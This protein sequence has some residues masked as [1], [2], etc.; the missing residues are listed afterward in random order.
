MTE[1]VSETSDPSDQDAKPEMSFPPASTDMIQVVD[2]DDN[3]NPTLNT[4]LTDNRLTTHGF[5][6]HVASILGAQSSGKSTLLNM[7]FGTR[8][9]T[10]DEASGRYQVTQG[11]W[12]GLDPAARII[13]LDLEGTDSRERGEGAVNFERKIALFALA[14]SEVL[15]VNVWAQDVGRYNA[16]N[17]DLL[18][19]VMEL[20][21]QLFFGTSDSSPKASVNQSSPSDDNTPISQ[22]RMHKTR[23]LFV[24]RDHVS[25]PFEA[26]CATLRTDVENIWSTISKP[27][28]AADIP[29]TH[30]FDLDFFALPH[31]ILMAPAFEEQGSELRRRFKDGEIF[32]EEYHSGIA[33]DGF[34]EYANA[35][36]E[37][38]RANRELDIPT[39]KEML[40]HVRCE[41]IAK[42]ALEGFETEIADVT[43]ALQGEDAHVVPDLIATLV[44]A[45]NTALEQYRDAAYRYSKPV[46]DDKGADLGSRI[47]GVAKDLVDVQMSI[48]S[49]AAV[50]SVQKSLEARGEDADE[51]WSG[52]NETRDSL[53]AK[54]LEGFG[55]TCGA[56]GL[57]EVDEEHAL[58][59]MRVMVEVERRRVE[60]RM[61][62]DVS[63][64]DA[65]IRS[66][67]AVHCASVFT[68]GM[69]GPMQAVVDAASD[70]VWERV[71]EVTDASWEAT[72]REARVV[73]GSDG[74]GLSETEQ[75]D[76]IEDVLKPTCHE[77]AVRS[78]RETIGSPNHLLMRMTKRFDDAFRFDER[79]VP[80]HFGPGEDIE[81]LFVA[82]RDRAEALVDVLA[83]VR[84]QGTIMELRDAVAKKV[85]KRALA[86]GEDATG[87]LSDEMCAEL[88][89][90]LKRQ[91][92][93]VFIEVKRAQE[94]ARVTA[95]V[96]MWLM[97]LI[98][99]L[100]WNEF[101]TVVKSPILLFM[102]VMVMPVM[103]VAYIVD[104]PTL[105]GPAI[106]ATVAPYADQ[107]KGIVEM[108]TEGG[109]DG[110][111]GAGAGGGAVAGGGGVGSEASSATVV[112]ETRSSNTTAVAAGSDVKKAE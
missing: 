53:V 96:P 104:A 64:V 58:A 72:A 6:Y 83:H 60:N 61:Q 77:T 105:L 29:L 80:R 36:W 59:P 68:K 73:Y 27:E 9:N 89:E 102:S 109:A 11:V 106:W 22:Q 47:L 8:F 44:T 32:E 48:A 40:A 1:P 100:G 86:D 91:A 69:K 99:I 107:A 18:K 35:V 66:R 10:M 82:A 28:S 90:K 19:T 110:T 92:G 57:D 95:K 93:A 112:S 54:V 46:A 12:L 34:S 41:Q 87:V 20:D 79:G 23:L 24:L 49:D 7:L 56:E 39:Q 38:I 74:I 33:S 94:A 45:C 14:L 78:I 31:K 26:L 2:Y 81:A 108:F 84:L 51:P 52:W 16:A 3:F 65:D 30:F 101:M 85:R 76:A 103:Y 70:D 50:A 25:S 5:D 43:T 67:G 98:L 4:F 111:A 17:M 15:I 75:D 55:E 13:V 42:E 88:R 62:G 97:V 37:T 21:L 71:S 63:R